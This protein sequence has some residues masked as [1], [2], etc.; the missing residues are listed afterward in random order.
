MTRSWGFVLYLLIVGAGV[1]GAA[2]TDSRVAKIAIL[3]LVVGAVVCRMVIRVRAVRA[4]PRPQ[5]IT[6]LAAVRYLPWLV[7][8]ELLGTAVCFVIFDSAVVRVACVASTV[9]VLVA[10]LGA[11]RELKKLPH[12]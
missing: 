12:R 1:F 9:V 3:A 11:L 4:S 8:L 7:A 10:G 2:A 6:D 5:D